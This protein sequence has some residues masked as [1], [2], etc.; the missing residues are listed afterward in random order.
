MRR[1]GQFPTRLQ[2]HPIQACR[3]GGRSPARNQRGSLSICSQPQLELSLG[4]ATH[5]VYRRGYQAGA[6][7]ESD[8]TPKKSC[9]R[10][11]RKDRLGRYSG[12]PE[13]IQMVGSKTSEVVRW[14]SGDTLDLEGWIDIVVAGD[15]V[16]ELND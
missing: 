2:F 15:D 12:L 14:R 13:G 8:A 11:A 5:L 6:L 1:V 4:S 7:S 9:E 10:R 16:S 3:L